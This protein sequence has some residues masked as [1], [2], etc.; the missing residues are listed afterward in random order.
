MQIKMEYTVRG[1]VY[2]YGGFVLVL[3]LARSLAL[4]IKS[5]I[6]GWVP[7]IPGWVPT[8]CFLVLFLLPLFFTLE[9]Q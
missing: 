1:Y 9:L 6:P 3:I 7:I 8:S 2:M 4:P 5:I